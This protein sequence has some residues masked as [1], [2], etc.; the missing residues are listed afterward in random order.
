MAGRVNCSFFYKIGACRH[1]ERCS[2]LHN[3]P[4]YSQTILIQNLY[5]NPGNEP[6]LPDGRPGASLGESELQAHFDDFFEDVFWELH[7]KYG[8]IGAARR[9][10]RRAPRTASSPRLWLQRR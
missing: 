8:E 3:R 2:R 6:V 9:G 10:G 4:T 5:K 1:G 7:D